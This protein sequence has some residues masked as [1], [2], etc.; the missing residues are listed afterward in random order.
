MADF[1]SKKL[2]MDI[3]FKEIGE[4]IKEA[5]KN[6]FPIMRKKFE[7]EKPYAAVFH[8]DSDCITLSLIVNTYE[9]LEKT[10]T[11]YAKNGDDE[12]TKWFPDEW[13]YWSDWNGS[14]LVK[15]SEEL[16]EKY[17]SITPG[18][19][20]GLT[21]DQKKALF[22]QGMILHE[23]SRFTELFF[24]TVT[25][26]FL[27]LIQSNVFDFDAEEITYFISM[28]DDDRVEEIENNSAK[29]LNSKKVYKKFLNRFD[30]VELE[31]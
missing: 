1:K 8:T 20:P 26:T 23:E 22:N 17:S 27:E 30:G 10:D 12:T 16:Y 21:V 13:G 5:V 25:S 18:Y 7:N 4:K 2:N 29:V 14:G 28:S 11:K 19:T 9:S 6:D 24:E 31:N 3:F 15:I